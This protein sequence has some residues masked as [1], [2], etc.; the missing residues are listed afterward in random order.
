MFPDIRFAARMLAKN[1]GTTAVAVIS[2]AIAIGPNCALFSMV[3]RLILKPPPVQGIGHIFYM[4]VRTDRPGE[5][6]RTSYADLQDYQAQAG[7]VASFAATFDRQ[8]VVPAKAGTHVRW[9]PAFAGM[10]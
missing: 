3:D 9:I 1:P 6:Q 7:D 10:T 2:L 5:W 4:E 8:D